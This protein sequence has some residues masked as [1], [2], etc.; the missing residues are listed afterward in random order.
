MANNAT[1]RSPLTGIGRVYC[2]TLKQT[3]G[4]KG[5]LL[6]TIIIGF[7]LLVVLPL[8]LFA[9]SSAGKNKDSGDDGEKDIRLVCVVDETE[10]EA[11]Y[12]VLNSLSEE[13]Y[14][15]RPCISMDEAIS[16][17]VGARDAVI[18]RVTKQDDAY[19][20]TVFLTQMTNVSRSRASSFGSF[21]ESGFMTILLQKANITPEGAA[22]LSMPVNAVTASV[23]ENAEVEQND[24]NSV[25]FI[26]GMLMPYFMMLLV[27]MMVV[28]Y[29]QS[30]ANSVMLE[31]TSKLMETILVSVHPFALLM[32]KLLAIA[33]SAVLQVLIW[34]AALAGGLFG[35][36]AMLLRV[37]PEAS[38]N[39]VV[40]AVQELTD[41]SSGIIS[42]PGIAV[43]LAFL[44]FG[45]LLYLSLSAVSGAV[46]SKQEDL[47][48]TNLIFTL[49]LVVSLLLT[50][51]SGMLDNMSEGQLPESPLW[52][53]LIPFTAILVM[54]GRLILGGESVFTTGLSIGV[55]ML[56][57]I[58]LMAAAAA[59]YKLLVL[60]R[61]ELLKPKQILAM[62][63]ESRN[64]EKTA[65]AAGGGDGNGGAV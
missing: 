41:L 23:N 43:S 1:Q 51:S 29:G 55:L 10:G 33:T 16:E 37:V 7:L 64:A 38:E 25:K 56:T 24:E 22:L 42:I 30:M 20:L 28:L 53:K 26:I 65:G 14:E 61:G 18:M 19:S 36:S 39:K 59:I 12:S 17:S 49:I 27:Y 52:L 44:A 4:T 45:F 50:M 47:T 60:Y 54:P 13:Q 35:G 46:A 32:G 21:V 8:V 11:D 57:V 9:A 15:F 48:K 6:S 40:S 2:F 62:M 58:L 34:L 31:K 63:K 5:W 3:V